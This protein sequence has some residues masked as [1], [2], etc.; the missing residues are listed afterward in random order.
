MRLGAFLPPMGCTSATW[1]DRICIYS[2]EQSG[3]GQSPTH[4]P[5]RGCQPATF[6]KKMS[7][8]KTDA[9]LTREE[10]PACRT[11]EIGGCFWGWTMVD[12]HGQG[13]W[14][15]K[16]NRNMPGWGLAS[17][18]PVEPL[19]SLLS[20]VARTP[21]C[22]FHIFD[23]STERLNFIRLQRRVFN[24]KHSRLSVTF[25]KNYSNSGFHF[26]DH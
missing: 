21:K 25:T 23:Q 4:G 2:A 18:R 12:R 22:G 26:E 20:K 1:S 16:T 5:E 10:W 8:A 15:D 7:A 3:R 9:N 19:F 14:A 11:G 17:R 13:C 6:A 24:C